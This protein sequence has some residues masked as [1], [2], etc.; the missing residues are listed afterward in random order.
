MHCSMSL[1]TFAYLKNFTNL[2]SESVIGQ[3]K[4]F[5]LTSKKQGNYVILCCW[6][7]LYGRID[8]LDQGFCCIIVHC[9]V[10]VLGWIFWFEQ[11]T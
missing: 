9:K 7:K 1:V 10:K 2:I 11:N 8:K 6:F 4:N 5:C 3:F